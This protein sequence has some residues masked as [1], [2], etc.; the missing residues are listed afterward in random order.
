MLKSAG[1]TVFGMA[2][3]VPDAMIEYEKSEQERT[4]GNALAAADIFG[5]YCRGQ[6]R[7]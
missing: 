5:L 6:W 4:K 2:L 3:S 7:W 1:G